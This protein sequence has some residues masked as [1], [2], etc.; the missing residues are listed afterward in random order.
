MYRGIGIG[1]VRVVFVTGY[2]REY[3]EELQGAELET[4]R[5][6]LRRG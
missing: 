1:E 5:V 2:Y 4:R 3:S 6:V